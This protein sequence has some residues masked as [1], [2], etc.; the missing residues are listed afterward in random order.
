MSSLIILST[1]LFSFSVAANTVLVQ[2]RNLPDGYRICVIGD[3]GK[4]TPDQYRVAHALLKDE[5]DEVRHTGDIIYPNGLESADDIQ[6]KTKFWWP[7]RGMLKSGDTPFYMTVGNHDYKE[8]PRAWLELAKRHESVVFPSMYYAQV[9]GDIC[10]LM[11]D[12]MDIGNP[13]QTEFFETF[14]R[15]NKDKCKISFAFGHHPYKSP[16]KNP[17][18]TGD[19]KKFIERIVVG[20]TDAFVAGHDH[21][22]A[23]E[24]RILGTHIFVSGAAGSKRDLRRAANRWAKSSLGYMIFTI[25]RSEGKVWA[26]YHFVAVSRL[27]PSTVE[28]RGVIQIRTAPL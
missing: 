1:L 4:G 6:F 10:F 28:N 21:V 13:K 14:N 26:D 19:Y 16:G 15:E 5:C 22:L 2:D 24:D 9:Q 7:Y 18:A 23:D 27:A 20:H 17:N 25:R 12:T 3:S 11:L 8:D